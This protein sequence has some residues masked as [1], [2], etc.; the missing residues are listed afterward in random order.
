MS[1]FAAIIAFDDVEV[2]IMKSYL[3]ILAYKERLSSSTRIT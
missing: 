3:H 2:A 1:L